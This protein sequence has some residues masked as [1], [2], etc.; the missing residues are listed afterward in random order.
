MREIKFRG[1]DHD[2]VWHYGD[3]AKTIA[4]CGEAYGVEPCLCTL[5]I[6]MHHN[7]KVEL[8]YKFVK[9]ETVGQYIGLKDKNSK[10]IYEGDV[11]SGLGFVEYSEDRAGFVINILGETNEIH[12]YEISLDSEYCK[13]EVIGSI[14]QNPEL[15]KNP[16][17]ME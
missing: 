2:G 13:L 12:F 6:D 10:E 3:L 9:P 7:D 14:Y 5:I 8:F 16:E 11:L 4:T 15:L 17:L 1:I